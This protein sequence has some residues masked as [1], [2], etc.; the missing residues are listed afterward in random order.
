MTEAINSRLMTRTE[1]KK[2]LRGVDPY[3][4][5]PPLAFG[6][7]LRWDRSEIDFAMEDPPGAQKKWSVGGLT[8]AQA[9]ADPALAAGE[10]VYFIQGEA[11]GLIKIGYSR[12]LLTR[13]SQLQTASADTL[14]LLA[15]LR[16]NQDRERELH[17]RFAP[18]RKHGEWFEPAKPLLR[19]IAERSR[20]A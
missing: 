5:C 4:V 12:N 20:P 19:Y 18:W 9:C 17:A 6:S 1:A 10:Y 8:L 15:R 7:A 14:R 2:Y 16:G 11:T 3:Q 13:F